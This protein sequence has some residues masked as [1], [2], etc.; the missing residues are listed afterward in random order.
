MDSHKTDPLRFIGNMFE[1]AIWPFPAASQYTAKE[2][3]Y[4]DQRFLFILLYPA[5]V[6]LPLICLLISL[7]AMTYVFLALP[8]FVLCQCVMDL[9]RNAIPPPHAADPEQKGRPANS[10]PAATLRC[11]RKDRQ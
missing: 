1:I 7:V 6:L 3:P 2:S 8:A 10:S 11:L 4:C 9:A 5:M